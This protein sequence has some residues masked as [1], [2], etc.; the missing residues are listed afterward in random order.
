MITIKRKRHFKTSLCKQ[1]ATLL[2]SSPIVNLSRCKIWCCPGKN[3][4]RSI[5]DRSF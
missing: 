2:L 4:E 3:D 5:Y 1:E